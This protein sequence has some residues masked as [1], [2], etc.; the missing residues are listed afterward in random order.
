MSQGSVPDRSILMQ[1]LMRNARK[2]LSVE[3][4]GEAAAVGSPAAAASS[5]AVAGADAAF[6]G[7]VTSQQ[8]AAPARRDIDLRTYDEVLF[9]LDA[10][11]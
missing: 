5:G 8:Q 4:G 2:Q 6:A 7:A 9:L 3:N 1:V 11:I 10:P